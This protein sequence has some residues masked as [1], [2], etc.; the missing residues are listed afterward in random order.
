MTHLSDDLLNEFL[1][2]ALAAESRAE[3]ETHLAICEMCSARLAE[4]RTLLANLDSL[5]ELPLEV[6]F[7]PVIVAR[8]GQ[9]TSLPRPIR[10]LTAAQAFGAILAGILGWPLV[11]SVFQPVN[12][13]S[14][15]NVFTESASFWLQT[16][17][18]FQFPSITFKFP[19][20]VINLPAVT[21]ILTVV[22]VSLLWLIANGLLLIP[23]SRRTS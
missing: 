19:S 9:K 12:L 22:C 5:P 18:N 10:W 8:L 21:L 11:E 23:R 3:T 7:V 13:P 16:I 2:E 6:N 17:T 1:D 15:S 14:L 4:L 20:L